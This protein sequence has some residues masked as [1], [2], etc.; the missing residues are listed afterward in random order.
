VD[1]LSVGGGVVKPECFGD[2]RGGCLE[3]ELSD[4]GDAGEPERHSEIA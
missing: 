4:G 3:G 1:G 2:D